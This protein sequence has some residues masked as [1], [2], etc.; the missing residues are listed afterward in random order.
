MEVKLTCMS[1]V[2][3]CNVVHAADNEVHGIGRPGQVIDLSTTRPTHV[4]RSP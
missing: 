3:S 4:F 1:V 2:D